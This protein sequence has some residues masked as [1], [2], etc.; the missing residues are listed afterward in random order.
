MSSPSALDAFLDKW[1]RRWPEWAVAET[2]VPAAQRARTVAW[3]ALLQEFDDILNIAGDP[4]PADAKLAWWGEELRNWAMQRSRHPLG[5]VLEPVAAPWAQLAEALPGL[6]A[7]RASAVDPGQAHAQLE[8]FAQVAAA[9]EC[10]LFDATPVDAATR[11]VATQVL[12]QRLAEVGAAAVPLSLRSG[13]DAQARQQWAQA[14]LQRWPR[15]V[16]GPRARRILSALARARIVRQATIPAPKPPTAM[17][18]LWRA[19][20]AGLG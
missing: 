1:R 13:D 2:F 5:R 4:L 3:F 19:W 10:A 9:V 11:A 15:R 6:L 20:W 14:L 7:A 8:S 18:T 16:R 17:A 12:A